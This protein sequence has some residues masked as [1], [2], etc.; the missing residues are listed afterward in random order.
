MRLPPGTRVLDLACGSGEML[1]TWARD[2]GLAGT[3]VDISSV[4][5]GSARERA[6]ELGV[7]DMVSFVHGEASGYVAREPVG[8]AACVG[9]TWIGGGVAGTVELLRRSLGP[10]WIMLIGE[11]YW[12]KEPPDQATVSGSSGIAQDEWM[13]GLGKLLGSFGELGLDVVEMVLADGDSWDRYEA[14]KWLS[15]RRWLDANPGDELY[16][17]M[18]AA[19]PGRFTGR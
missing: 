16:G 19:L 10:G 4:F 9:A 14:A 6:R 7:E 1:C 15:I 8:A 12:R 2:H 13:V 3:G 11:P 17:E 18:R 5:I